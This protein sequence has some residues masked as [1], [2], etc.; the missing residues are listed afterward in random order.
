M[1]KKQSMS[2]QTISQRV[3]YGLIAFI[4]IAFVA[5]F[6]VGFNGADSGNELL[7]APLLIDVLLYMIYSVLLSAVGCIAFSSC[8]SIKSAL[9]NKQSYQFNR[10]HKNS[11]IIF[12]GLFLCLFVSYLLAPS[13]SFS[14]NGMVYADT[15]WN[16]IAD[17]FVTTSIIIMLLAELS[18]MVS[19]ILSHKK[20]G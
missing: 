11:F 13:T 2:P 8:K 5:F 18:M 6:F 1:R 10:E 20:Q 4:A 16:K 17:M 7:G 9:K 14:H 12:G 15:F 19:F 3:L